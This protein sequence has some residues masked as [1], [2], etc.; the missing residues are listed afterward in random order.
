MN[1]NPEEV[2]MNWQTL[3]PAL[4][5]LAAAFDDNRIIAHFSTQ[6]AS[7]GNQP[8]TRCRRQS[9]DYQPEQGCTTTYLLSNEDASWQ[10]IGVV[11]VVPD[12]VHHRFFTDDPALA[13]M[14]TAMNTE[15]L[16]S[17]SAA[18]HKTLGQFVTV[19]PIR[20]K[21]GSR[22]TLR[23][24]TA[25]ATGQQVCFG[26]L[27]AHEGTEIAN[28]VDALYQ[29]SQQ[30]PMAAAVVQPLAYWPELQ[31]LVQAAV[32]GQELHDVAFDPRINL[33]T[34]LR[35]MRAA[36]QATAALHTAQ[37][38]APV[39]HHSLVDDLIALDQ[40]Q[41]A[42]CRLNP[43]LATRFVEAIELVYA[44]ARHQSELP[45]MLS[46]GALRTDQFMIEDGHLVLIDLDSLCLSSPARDL[47]NFLG[48]L[49]W[50]ELR[51]RQHATFIQLGKAAFL[52]G[53]RSVQ[54]LPPAEWIALY[55]TTSI[56][57]VLGR[58]YTGLT[59]REW[60][61]TEQLLD[62]GLNLLAMHFGT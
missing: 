7:S 41:P 25:H 13:G 3:D 10:T 18:A 1:F 54:P 38:T 11:D 14:A 8:L 55:H 34:R 26:K 15:A 20:Y 35:W 50:K 42:L 6:S 23:Y 4:P 51:Q 29:T 33:A 49:T 56:L 16:T 62:S 32:A 22:C 21:P 53:Y 52:E 39:P 47:G 61:L 59:V 58:R 28:A 2:V 31:M 48:Y 30:K 5:Q 44:K 12:G 45:A 27:L 37:L 43:Q 19:M 46:H 60:P 57:K 36:G 40:Y 17:H 9:I 24:Q